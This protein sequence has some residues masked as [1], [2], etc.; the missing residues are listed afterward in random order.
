MYSVCCGSVS[1]TRE[2]GGGRRGEGRDEVHVQC[3][4]W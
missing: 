2:G 1:V 4:L 3:V